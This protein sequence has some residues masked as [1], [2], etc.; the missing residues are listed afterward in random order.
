[1]GEQQRRRASI[2]WLSGVLAVLGMVIAIF[3]AVEQ[4]TAT[5]A[6]VAVAVV[7][8]VPLVKVLAQ[9]ERR[10]RETPHSL[11]SQGKSVD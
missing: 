5:L 9:T 7:A 4:F 10:T 11:S 3:A 2:W 6:T 1:M 8:T